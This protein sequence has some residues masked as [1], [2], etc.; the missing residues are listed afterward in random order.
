MTKTFGIWFLLIVFLQG[1]KQKPLGDLSVISVPREANDAI[2]LSII[3]SVEQ[4]IQLETKEDAF[5][6]FIFDVKSYRD[7]VFVSDGRKISIFDLNGNYVQNLG[8]HGD[9]PGEFR[10]V[11]SMDIDEATGKIYVSAGYKLMVYDSAFQLIDERKL[12]YRLN[13]L[14]VIEGK[15]WIVSEEIAVKL[16]DG[17]IANQTNIYRLDKDYENPDTVPFR[18]INMDQERVGGYPF[19]HWISDLDGENFMFMPVLTPENLLRDTLYRI[20]GNTIKPAVRFQFERPQSL[21]ENDYQTLLL[22]NIVNSKSYYLL[23]Y[24]QDWKRFMFLYD[25]KAQKGY[26]LSEG[27]IDQAGDAVFLRPLDLNQDLFYYI[28]KV[29]FEDKSIEEQNPLIGIVKLK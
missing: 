8:N 22:Y 14:K 20:E 26:N 21:D 3:G 1:C 19:R 10:S 7:R 9:G 28:K 24:D 18:A 13:F 23:E 17:G 27:L 6:R 15:L 12:D 4:E 2:P 5:L 25:K 16:G 29:E 11:S